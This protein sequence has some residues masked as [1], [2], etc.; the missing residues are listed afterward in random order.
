M[1]YTIRYRAVSEDGRVW[2][3]I[4]SRPARGINDAWKKAFNDLRCAGFVEF[5]VKRVLWSKSD[6][7]GI[8]LFGGDRG[9]VGV[10]PAICADG[11]DRLYMFEKGKCCG[12]SDL[13]YSWAENL[14]NVIENKKLWE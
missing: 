2:E 1:K 7:V 3:G 9:R 8:H 4:Y 6:A 11:S 13:T 10:I 14:R 12:I 5:S